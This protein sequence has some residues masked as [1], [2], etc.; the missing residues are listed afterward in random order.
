MPGMSA[1]PGALRREHLERIRIAALDAVEPARAVARFLA[2]DGDVLRAGEARLP[3]ASR[4]SV[5][6]VAAGKAATAMTESAAPVLGERLERGVLV[7]KRGHLGG[8]SIPPAVRRLEAGHPVP[9]EAGRA[10]VAAVEGLLSDL[11]EGDVVLALLSGGASALLADPAEPLSLE[12][13]G[14]T[15][16]LLLRSGATIGELNAVRKHLSR[17]KG[18]QLA[19]LAAPASVVALILSD[20]VGD[21][22]DVIAS[23]PTAPDPTTFADA[24]SVVAR[25]GLA[26]ALPEAVGNRLRDGLE[27]RVPETPKPGDP[28][29]GRVHN[30]VVGSNRLAALAAVEEARSLGYGALLLST[31]VEGEA[32]EVARVVAALGRGVLA[33][34]DPLAAPACLVLGGETT[35]TVR[36]SGHGGRNQELAL[37]A[38]L[39]LEGVDG[40]SVMALATDGSDGPT[41]SSGAVVDGATAGAIRAAGLDPAAALA[42]ND[43]YPAL[44]AAGA[45]LRT[46]PT[47]TNVNDLTV[48]LVTH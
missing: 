42:A 10:G 37:A 47:G 3:L 20:V 15:T 5:R 14:E 17:L 21:P 7:T 30:V 25:R 1:P 35:V 44:S 39:A 11:R 8:R 38:A 22:L 48:V 16:R 19:R 28:L 31:F 23:G 43:A 13:L 4:A 46:G 12:D 45:Q 33:H 2:R 32:R 34:G 9:D 24:W 29:F 26:G 40:V 6:L 41:D 36:G 18:G 27:G